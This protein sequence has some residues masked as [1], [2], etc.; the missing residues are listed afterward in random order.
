MVKLA[1]ARKSEH[2]RI[3]CDALRGAFNGIGIV[4][5]NFSVAGNL[6]K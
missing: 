2:W 6:D 3:I 1:F 5:P 4:R